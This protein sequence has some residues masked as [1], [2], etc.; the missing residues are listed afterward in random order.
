MD[1]RDP[2][3]ANVNIL[4]GTANELDKDDQQE[5]SSNDQ[6]MQENKP[7]DLSNTPLQD[8]EIKERTTQNFDQNQKS[9][10]KNF[11][12]Y[13]LKINLRDDRVSLCS[14]VAR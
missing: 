7:I 4:Q 1:K 9:A 5:E 3:E 6:E 13:N 8:Q 11:A 12:C 10:G 14:L 2:N